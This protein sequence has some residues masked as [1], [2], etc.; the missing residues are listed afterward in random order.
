MPC[1][2]CRA[3]E[4]KPD[5]AASTMH[6]PDMVKIESFVPPKEPWEQISHVDGYPRLTFRVP[7]TCGCVS[8][9]TFENPDPVAALIWR[10][11]HE[12]PTVL[13]KP[14]DYHDRP[15][16][17]SPRPSIGDI[18]RELIVGVFGD[19]LEFGEPSRMRGF[20]VSSQA[21]KVTGL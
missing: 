20:R 8:D 1:P 7:W 11:N 10:V 14:D 16:R 3:A 12:P 5:L 19:E 18:A 15:G 9:Y 17:L 21:G 2:K 6:D 4:S 13:D